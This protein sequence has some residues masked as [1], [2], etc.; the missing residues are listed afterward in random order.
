MLVDQPNGETLIKYQNPY[1]VKMLAE[2]IV[3]TLAGEKLKY[4]T[5]SKEKT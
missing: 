5:T 4:E 3:R 1:D 2:C